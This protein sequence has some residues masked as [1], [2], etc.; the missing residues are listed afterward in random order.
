MSLPE[1]IPSN[2]PQFTQN[3]ARTSFSNSV[4]P[5]GSVLLFAES[6]GNGGSNLIAKN[7][8]GSFTEVGGGSGGTEF[9]ECASVDTVN[10]TWTGYKAVLNNGVYTFESTAT[11][12]LSYTSVTPE[13]GKVYSSDALATATLYEGIPSDG[14]LLYA[15]LASDVAT[16]ETGQY[17]VKT[18]TVTYETFNGIPG[19]R[20]QQS[21]YLDFSPAISY[22]TGNNPFTIT[23]WQKANP[24]ASYTWQFGT[25]NDDRIAGQACIIYYNGGHVNNASSFPVSANL[26]FCVV[27][28]D[29]S[30]LS[31]YINGSLVG[32]KTTDNPNTQNALRLGRGNGEYYGGY[33]AAFRIYNRVLTS[34][35]IAALAAEFTPTA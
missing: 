10:H 33:L 25:G 21:G 18:G 22:L 4:V 20:F 30:T 27:T 28:Y 7:P 5:S 17:I 34:S 8:D 11:T 19:A 13:V 16:C 15:S 24:Y 23:Y 6:D 3:R 35:E 12:G 9:Y 26:M 29:G 32:S 1:I 14:L 31:Y 2:L